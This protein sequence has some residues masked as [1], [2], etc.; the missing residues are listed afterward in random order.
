MQPNK[1]KYMFLKIKNLNDI[2]KRIGVIM[3]Q[4]QNYQ[5][6]THCPR[7]SLFAPIGQVLNH[8]TM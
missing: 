3:N 6:Y 4:S 5:A 1:N 2:Y 8:W 7:Q